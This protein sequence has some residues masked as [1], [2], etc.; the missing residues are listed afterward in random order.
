MRQR[1]KKLRIKDRI[2]IYIKETKPVKCRVC[3]VIAAILLIAL[4][5]LGRTQK[6]NVI[7]A[8]MPLKEENVQMRLTFAGD[9]EI[10]DGIRKLANKSSYKNLFEGVQEYWNDSDYVI[11]N[12]SG[13]V[14]Q[15]NVSHYKSTRK[16]GEDSNYL[17]PAA[18]RGLKEAGINL[19]GFANDDVYNY[20]VTG[21]ESTIRIL[22]KYNMDYLG[23]ISN[24]NEPLYKILEYDFKTSSGELETRKIGVIGINDVLRKKSTVGENKA[25]IIN[26][27][28]QPIYEKIIEMDEMCDYVIAYTHLKNGEENTS[29][30]VEEIAKVLIDVG[31]DVVIGNSS[32]LESMEVYEGKYIF[33]GLGS[34]VSDEAYSFS[35]NSALFDF[36]VERDGDVSIY[37]TPLHITEGRPGKVTSEMNLKKIHATVLSNATDK[38]Y[39]ILD[40]GLIKFS[41][42]KLP[43][44]QTVSEEGQEWQNVE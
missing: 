37:L 38:D 25:G 10:T 28:Y 26:S 35:R 7:E 14:L 2:T 19:P 20:G 44:I 9:I 41:L 18:L 27:S 23:I 33:Y 16:E 42:G 11:A 30:E 8:S 13:P 29:T 4:I 24:S 1:K 31:A 22:E 5:I 40:D 43:V 32:A 34:L 21:I 17:R 36:T 6:I 3:L 15:Y 12:I 39:E